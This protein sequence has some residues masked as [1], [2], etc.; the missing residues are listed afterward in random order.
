MYYRRGSP[1]NIVALKAASRSIVSGVDAWGAYAQNVAALSA[2]G[3]LAAVAGAGRV[4]STRTTNGTTTTRQRIWYD[5][6]TGAA[7]SEVPIARVGFGVGAY[8]SLSG[9]V[10]DSINAQA[11]TP[12]VEQEVIAPVYIPSGTRLA[13]RSY[14]TGD[15][16]NISKRCYLVMYDPSLLA[17]LSRWPINQRAYI[18]GIGNHHND[19]TPDTAEITLTGTAGAPWSAAGAYAEI[20]A[21]LANNYLI[22]GIG[23]TNAGTLAQQLDI[24]LGA[25]GSEV[26][27]AR[28]AIPMDVGVALPYVTGRPF[29]FPVPWLAYKG[30]RV[31]AR[32][33]DNVGASAT[34][35]IRLFGIRLGKSG[36]IS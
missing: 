1:E 19:D 3:I 10:L 22:T 6:A 2:N 31:A 34:T 33:W 24:A 14:Q 18:E 17:C 28:A 27:H 11:Q 20:H 35:A 9:Q 26:I 12:W 36:A 8:I 25:A 32:L 7:A 13:T 29:A 15:S 16:S 21:G 30:E 4:V 23:V 5:V